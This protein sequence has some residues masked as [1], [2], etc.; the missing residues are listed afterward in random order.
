[1]TEAVIVV[2]DHPGPLFELRACCGT[3]GATIARRTYN[4]HATRIED[5]DLDAILDASAMATH[6]CVE[7]LQ[8][9]GH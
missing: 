9:N 6:R 1:M 7:S 8:R 4:V 3:C 5:V 2:I